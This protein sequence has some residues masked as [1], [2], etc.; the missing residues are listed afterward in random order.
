MMLLSRISYLG[1]VK[2]LVSFVLAVLIGG[3]VSFLAGELAGSVPEGL[4]AIII[5]T[6]LVY[7]GSQA[8]YHLWWKPLLASRF[9]QAQAKSPLS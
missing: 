9:S 6:S 2:T 8:A 4:I 5:D 3:T 1:R 7:T